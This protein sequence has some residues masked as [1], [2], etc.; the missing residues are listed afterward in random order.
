MQGGLAPPDTLAPVTLMVPT[1]VPLKSVNRMEPPPMV[2]V[3][4]QMQVEVV[5]VPENVTPAL[6]TT[7]PIAGS[8]ELNV[9]VLIVPVTPFMY[10]EPIV[11]KDPVSV[12]VHDT[13]LP[14]VH[15]CDAPQLMPSVSRVHAM[16]SVRT[17]EPVHEPPLHVGVVQVRLWLADSSQVP[18]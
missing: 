6:A 12:G 17:D 15:T 5:A 11:P 3:T 16:L 4:C 10:V 13:Q 18:E 14:A 8:P 1:T 2:A 7:S 9:S